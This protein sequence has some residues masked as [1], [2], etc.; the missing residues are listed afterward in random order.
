MSVRGLITFFHGTTYE[1]ALHH[2]VQDPRSS[3][4]VLYGDHDQFTSLQRYEHW[5]SRLKTEAKGHLSTV[6]INGADHF[7]S[8]R[9]SE[10][11]CI[12]VGSWLDER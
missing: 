7:W 10:E 2:L 5:V 3:V 9:A 1:T 12:T 4:L 8:Q 6:L 11:M